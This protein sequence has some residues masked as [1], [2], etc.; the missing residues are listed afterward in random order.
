MRTANI[1]ER[2]EEVLLLLDTRI[3][4]LL[5]DR[6]DAEA[7]R[8]QLLRLRDKLAREPVTS[9]TLSRIEALILDTRLRE[10][11]PQDRVA[12]SAEPAEATT[13]TGAR[14]RGSSAPPE[15]VARCVA[16][17]A[18]GLGLTELVLRLLI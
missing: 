13:V 4:C 11:V 15:A 17:M 18:G 9:D 2:R 16:G 3:A 6:P 1:R 5:V 8:A 10:G 7:L 12:A 14:A